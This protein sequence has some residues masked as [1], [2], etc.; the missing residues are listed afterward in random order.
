[1]KITTKQRKQIN[2]QLYALC[3]NRHD[4]IPTGAINAILEPHGFHLEDGIYT[5]RNGRCT[6]PVLTPDNKELENTMLVLSWDKGE[7]TGTYEINSYLS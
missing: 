3:L 4:G 5:G 1:M 2:D 6:E 7:Q